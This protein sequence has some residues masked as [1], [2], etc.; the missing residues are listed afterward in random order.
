MVESKKMST[1]T[2][3]T[4]ALLTALVIALQYVSMAIRTGTFSI[5]LALIPIVIGAITCGKGM[6]AWLGM[7][8][9]ITVLATGDAA[10]F[11]MVS[12]PGTVITVLA[13]GTACGFVAGLVYQIVEK[14]T[15]KTYLAGIISAIACP[16]VNTGIFLIGCLVFVMDTVNAGAVSE[17]MSVGGY[18]IIFFVGLNFVFEL[19]ANILLSPAILRII[20]IKRK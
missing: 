1:R 2:M 20:N 12:V 9:G 17:G 16:V 19:L 3:V 15:S 13:K 6:G 10:P 4:G 5:T 7:V 8:F 14:F 11:M 18:L